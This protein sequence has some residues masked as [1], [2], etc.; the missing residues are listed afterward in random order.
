MGPPSASGAP[1]GRVPS[2][3]GGRFKVL[4]LQGR[5]IRESPLHDARF[6][7]AGDFGGVV[8]EDVGEDF[9][10]VLA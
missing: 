3:E 4:L 9:F 1:V 10:A 6:A 5:A 2:Q 8:A 7:E